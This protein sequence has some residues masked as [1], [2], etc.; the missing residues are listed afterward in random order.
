MPET[1]ETIDQLIEESYL[2][3]LSETEIKADLDRFVEIC[4]R[5]IHE[6]VQDRKQ[7]QRLT[8]KLARAR[9]VSFIEEQHDPEPPVS[10]KSRDSTFDTGRRPE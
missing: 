1:S 2:L 10:C 8:E 7:I 4:G 9:A 3:G 6:H 5:I